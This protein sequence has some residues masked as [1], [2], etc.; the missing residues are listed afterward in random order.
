MKCELLSL[1]ILEWLVNCVVATEIDKPKKQILAHYMPWYV[2]KTFNDKWG[3]HWTMNYYNPDEVKPCGQRKIA[4]HYYPIIGP[5][6]SADPDVLECQILLMKFTGIDG[7]IID[8]Y[9]IEDFY[10]YNMIN[11]NTHQIIKFL[12]K[13]GLKF[14]ICYED[15]SVKYM[16]N[17]GHISD[18]EAIE[19]GKKVMIWLQE[20]CF[21]RQNYLKLNDR[22]VLLVFGPQYFKSDH[23][24]KIFSVLIRRPF[25]YTI[26]RSR[27][28]QDIADGYFGWVPVD[29][30]LTEPQKW[31]EYLSNLYATNANNGSCI[32]IVFPQFHDIYEDAKV[33]KSYGFID[34]Q[35]TKTFEETFDIALKSNCDLIQIATWNDYGEGTMIEPTV[36]LGYSYLEIIQ[37]RKGVEY[38]PDDLRLPIKLYKLKKKYQQDQE[39]MKK[40]KRC[41]ELLFSGKLDD[42]RRVIGQF[43]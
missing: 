41:T 34:A 40:L 43:D 42:A 22:P 4:S 12:E 27:D 14:A 9:G 29:G 38:R 19:H 18:Q 31:Q 17:A 20:N 33:H 30:G 15:Q 25:F 37:K 1:M 11:K 13:A 35:G 36:E 28:M 6:D 39:L 21:D 26:D 24:D 3:W 2:S 7:I 5:Y 32:G 8:W 10:D 23:W 16:V